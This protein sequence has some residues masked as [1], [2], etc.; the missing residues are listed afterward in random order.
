M[1]ETKKRSFLFY[2]AIDF[3]QR[4]NSR[5][6]DLEKFNKIIDNEYKEVDKPTREACKI[7]LKHTI[8]REPSFSDLSPILESLADSELEAYKG[9][10]RDLIANKSPKEALD[11]LTKITRP[12][13]IFDRGGLVDIKLQGIYAVMNEVLEELPQESSTTPEPNTADVAQEQ[14]K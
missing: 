9:L 14:P 3:D 10:I 6:S 11:L 8:E 5:L 2:G 4:F 13:A 1:R 12:Q 7:I